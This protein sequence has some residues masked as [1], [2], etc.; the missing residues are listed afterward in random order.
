MD[1]SKYTT[2]ADGA[3]ISEDGEYTCRQCEE[4]LQAT[5]ETEVARG[6]ERGVFQCPEC[7]SEY[8]C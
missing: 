3:Y 1:Y 5:G 7:E 6:H 4:R 2:G 8:A